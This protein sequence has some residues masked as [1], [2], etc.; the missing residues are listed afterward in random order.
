MDDGGGGSEEEV[1]SFA[2]EVG[3]VFEGVSSA[4]YLWVIFFGRNKIGH[5]LSL[6]TAKAA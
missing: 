2:E 4:F 1:E 3:I 6:Q 5:L